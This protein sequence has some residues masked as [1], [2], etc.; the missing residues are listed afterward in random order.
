MK[1]PNKNLILIKATETAIKIY[2]TASAKLARDY[3]DAI[4]SEYSPNATSSALTTLNTVVWGMQE[5]A[6]D[7]KLAVNKAFD[8]FYVKDKT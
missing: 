3:V 4:R 1:Q 8:D 6:D 7:F 5:C 2:Q